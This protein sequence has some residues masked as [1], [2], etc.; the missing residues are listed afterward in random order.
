VT[1]ATNDELQKAIAKLLV[2]GW[3]VKKTDKSATYHTPDGD[4]PAEVMVRPIPDDVLQAR[5]SGLPKIVK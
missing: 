1:R 3:I 2:E 5:I 4:R